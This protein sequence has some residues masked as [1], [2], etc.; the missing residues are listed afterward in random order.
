MVIIE[1][2]QK[3]ETDHPAAEALIKE[4]RQRQHGRWL[5]VISAVVVVLGAAVAVVN[6]ISGSGRT[7]S[8]TAPPLLTPASIFA[9]A[10]LGT[11]GT[12]SAVYRL[13]GAASPIA[14][15][16]TVTIA[17][18][19]PADMVPSPSRGIG[20]WSYRLTYRDGSSLEFVVRGGLLEDCT[21]LRAGKW[22]CTGPGRFQGFHCT[23]GC[24]DVSN[25][26]MF[27]TMLYLPSVAFNLLGLTVEARDSLHPR[28]KD[29]S[30]GPLTC[31]GVVSDQTLCLLSNGKLYSITGIREME[32]AW[33][34]A[35]LLSE[36]S[37]APIAD[38]TLSGTPKE[39][40]ILPLPGLSN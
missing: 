6:G 17:Q 30:F 9:R 26:Y 25:G 15:N 12:F 23:Y 22:R 13:S 28:S 7:R 4:A 32:F 29:S 20:E 10:K 16:A 31:V 40:Y 14:N 33:T 27:A 34:T 35:R 38:F 1:K 39:P 36:Q 21:R 2:I 5:I 8:H 19:A 24:I 18:R 37:T 11:E 3:V